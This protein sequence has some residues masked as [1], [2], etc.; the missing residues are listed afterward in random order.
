MFTR[1][2]MFFSTVTFFLVL[3]FTAFAEEPSLEKQREALQNQV[4][5][6]LGS[7][8]FADPFDIIKV[9]PD[10]LREALELLRK[11]EHL[12]PKS[13][14]SERD[15][16]IRWRLMLR[17]LLAAKVEKTE[18]D[19]LLLE[20]LKSV[21]TISDKDARDSC[22]EQ[23][24]DRQ[25]YGFVDTEKIRTADEAMKIGKLEWRDFAL[26]SVAQKAVRETPPNFAEA[27]RAAKAISDE[28]IGNRD[29]CLGIIAV[30]QARSGLFDD[31]EK[32]LELIEGVGYG[33]LGFILVFAPLYEEH[34]DPV[35][36]KK[37]IDAAF[38]FSLLNEESDMAFNSQFFLCC[39]DCMQRLKTPPLR[40]YLFDK[41]F[42]RLKKYENERPNNET[43]KSSNLLA[44]AI[45]AAM[46]G[47]R[48]SSAGFFREAE[49]II[50]ENEKNRPR[51]IT[52]SDR[53]TLIASLLDAGFRDE[54]RIML[55]EYLKSPSESQ[56]L[57]WF[58]QT[59]CGFGLYE[60]AMT[61]AVK[62]PDKK[63][64]FEAYDWF[65]VS[66]RYHLDEPWSSVTIY[67]GKKPFGSAEEI[68]KIAELLAACPD[69]DSLDR[70]CTKIRKHAD[71][72]KKGKK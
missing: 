19:A 1:R 43:F 42:R 7:D 11:S 22:I 8:D 72:F 17:V 30:S 58:M 67:P 55:E 20:S 6:I 10:K 66:V 5:K 12:Y 14:P 15:D 26:S 68:R 70:L 48:E 54:G 13:E 18:A 49:A 64:R 65:E 2:F 63:Q 33:K 51:F 57:Y 61:V 46:L 50:V 27:L 4:E 16:F 60:E 31:A 21:K 62:I 71:R 9:E 38:E 59:L 47:D 56:T 53:R 23:I 52:D 45:A 28:D 35:S 29:L 40:G 32:T 39:C 69:G 37:K 34:G 44:I 36:A 3:T 24:R 25:K 41:M